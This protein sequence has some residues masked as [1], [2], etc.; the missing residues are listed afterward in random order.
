VA[1]KYWGGFWLKKSKKMFKDIETSAKG[2]TIKASMRTLRYLSLYQ[3][4]DSVTK[5]APDLG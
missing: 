1:A 3:C 2:T 4:L 5:A